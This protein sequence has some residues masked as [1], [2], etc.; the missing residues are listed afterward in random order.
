[1]KRR[2]AE[3]LGVYL[4]PTLHNSM[5]IG[6]LLRE[7]DDTVR[8]VVDEAYLN[9]GSSRPI[10]SAGWWYPSDDR[11]T[12]E[13]LRDPRGKT[14]LLGNL[15]PWFKN[16]IPEGALRVAIERQM[17]P[18]HHSDFDIMKRV[19]HD[20]PGAVVVRD[21]GNV[22][23][24]PN[25]GDVQDDL[26]PIRFGLAGVQLKLSVLKDGEGLTV[27][28]EGQFGSI[29]AKLPSRQRGLEFLPE[30]EFA[31]MCLAEAVGVDV[32]A[33]ELI[34]LQKLHGIGPEHRKHGDFALAVTRFDRRPGERVHIED[35]A[36]IFGAV[37]NQ[38][39]TLANEET[40]W[41]GVKRF[42][43]DPNGDLLEATRRLVVNILLGNGDAHLKNT[44]LIYPDGRTVRLSKAYDIVPTVCLDG[45]DTLAIPFGRAKMMSDVTFETF[46]RPC[47]LLDVEP[48]LL[49]DEARRTIEKAADT[50]PGLLP[51]L[52]LPEHHADALR[53]RWESVALTE[54]H[55][56]VSLPKPTVG[57]PI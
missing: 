9:L 41:N 8:F 55:W 11:K 42:S 18:G 53:K 27:P 56:Q 39:Y 19:G 44:S 23:P 31:A 21:E 3:M 37:D 47:M 1:M 13:R 52:P 57:G 16:V 49:V 35:F 24:S 28:A 29:I 6:S 25:G 34:P 43:T 26:P 38:K 32:A 50:W 45:D 15:P 14:G 22:A 54:G 48:R 30:L 5:R 7:P 20:L 40:L 51:N 2:K 33:C 17:G 36:Q 12:I 46:R 4:E 10:L